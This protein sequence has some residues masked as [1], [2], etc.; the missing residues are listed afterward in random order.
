MEQLTGGPHFTDALYHV[1]AL[2]NF[3]ED[4]IA[5]F[6]G[7]LAAMVERGIVDQIDE[8]LAGGGVGLGGTRHR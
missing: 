4:G 2:G 3:A 6:G 8:K 1:H 7:A 5:V